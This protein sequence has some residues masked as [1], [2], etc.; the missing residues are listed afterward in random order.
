MTRATSVICLGFVAYM[1]GWF[2]C[3]LALETPF[4]GGFVYSMERVGALSLLVGIPLL[5]IFQRRIAEALPMGVLARLF[6]I[7]I[8]WG[9]LVFFSW[10]YVVF[11][12][13][14]TAP[15]TTV[16]IEGP[17][18]EK[19]TTSGKG[20]G[21]LVGVVDLKTHERVNFF[22]GKDRYDDIQIGSTYARCMYEGRFGIPFVW[23]H[24]EKRP[25]C[26]VGQ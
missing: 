4:N 2:A 8:V 17:V 21:Y 24:A 10:T 7:A 16:L 11:I 13:A 3:M 18:A 15:G 22:V 9:G 12:N 1:A 23:R 20:R 14:V 6:F 25:V 26:R 5:M 19:F